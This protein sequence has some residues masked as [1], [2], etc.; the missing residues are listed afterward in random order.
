MNDARRSLLKSFLVSPA[1]A[2][3]SPP[4]VVENERSGK[5][6]LIFR[7]TKPVPY[8]RIEEL[9]ALLRGALD[10]LGFNDVSAILLPE[11][12]ELSQA[13]SQG[14]NPCLASERSRS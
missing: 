2:F 4:Q 5:T 12:L 8:Q 14:E 13:L 10:H 9:N 1:A 11:Y 7:M 6:L 3:L